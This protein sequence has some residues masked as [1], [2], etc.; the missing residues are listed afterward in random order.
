MFV[1]A[2]RLYGRNWKE[3]KLYRDYVAPRTPA[4]A[5]QL[6]IVVPHLTEFFESVTLAFI[7][8]FALG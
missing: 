4:H 3:V 8:T 2:L 7:L 1:E 6:A 5:W